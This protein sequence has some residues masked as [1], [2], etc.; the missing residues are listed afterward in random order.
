MGRSMDEPVAPSDAGGDPLA[1]AELTFLLGV[2]FQTLLAE[3][4]GE[5]N[6]AGYS[7]LRPMHG[8][9][10]QVVQAAGGC[11][12]S[13]LAEVLGVTKQ[14]AG[15]IVKDLEARDYLQREPHPEGGRRVLY[16]MTEKSREH[17]RVA[18]SILFRLEGRLVAELGEDGMSGLRE[19]LSQVI[20][21]L[22]GDRIPPLR[23]VW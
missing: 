6:Q 7:D 10:F 21:E 15:Q 14:A 23:P 11:T 18:G 17:M 8:L 2:A 22:V 9:V 16:T 20:R 1:D 5:L 19:R 3:F 4:V 12:S 13:E